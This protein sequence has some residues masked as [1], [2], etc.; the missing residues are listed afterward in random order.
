MVSKQI[1]VLGGSHGG[2]LACHLLGQFPVIKIFTNNCVCTL[3]SSSVPR[4][5]STSPPT[6][7]SYCPNSPPNDQDFY[8]A[9][10]VRNPAINLATFVAGTDIPDWAMNE[11][12]LTYDPTKPPSSNDVVKLLSLSPITLA[13]KV[14]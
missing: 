10:S 1:A 11:A 3:L 13:D 6:L 9:A 4:P 5:I 7:P 2:Y 14:T 12:G 8:K